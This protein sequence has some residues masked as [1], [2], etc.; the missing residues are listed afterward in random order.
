MGYGLEH[1]AGFEALGGREY[2]FILADEYGV[3]ANGA[4]VDN[5]DYSSYLDGTLDGTYNNSMYAF[6][7]LLGGPEVTCM[8]PI[9]FQYLLQT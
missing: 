4:L 3:D 8:Q 6:C 9:R 7:Q 2:T 1:Q 5:P